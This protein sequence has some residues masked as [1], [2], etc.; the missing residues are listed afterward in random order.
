MSGLRDETEQLL[1]LGET[2]PDR[3]MPG[4]FR[5]LTWNVQHAAEKRS[6]TQAAW[7][8]QRED[9]DVLV[10]TEVG[11][12]PGGLALAQALREHG[13]RV[14]E[15]VCAGDKYLT[16]LACRLD[17]MVQVD[18]GMTVMPH[19]APAAR[20]ATGRQ[21]VVVV[22]LYVPSRGGPGEQRNVAKRA[23]QDA[24]AA[25]LPKLIADSGDT[26]LVVAGDLNVLE[27]GHQP[28]HD[29]FGVWEYDFYR[30]FAAAGLVDAFRAL[31][32]EAVEHS[33]FGRAGNG[34]RFDHGFVSAEH[35]DSIRTCTYL[36]EPRLAGLSDHA[37]ML[38]TLDFAA[39]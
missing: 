9:A 2:R 12:G 24:F 25:R 6:R 13:Y 21:A 16:I 29:V 3:P 35:A 1:L 22:G 10:L 23:V 17:E 4:A 39:V 31:H 15:P 37:A 14:M 33:W 27:P 20:I 36:Q 8:A 26:P 18:V 34:Y 28:H 38:L 30:A 32:P 5:I 7:L 11:H 19:R